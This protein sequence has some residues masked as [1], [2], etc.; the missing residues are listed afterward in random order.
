VEADKP[1]PNLD[2]TLPPFKQG[3][4]KS[5]THEDGLAADGLF[6][7]LQA[8]DGAMWFGTDQGCVPIR[9]TLFFKSAVRG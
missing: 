6:C 5:Y 4:W 2:F 3:Q 7:V 8:D 1:L 9:R